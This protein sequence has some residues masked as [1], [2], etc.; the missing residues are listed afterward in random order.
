MAVIIL[1]LLPVFM[2]IAL[3]YGLRRLLLKQE[4][5]WISLERLVYYILF[6]ALLIESLSQANLRAVPVVEVGLSLFAAVILM[7]LLCLALRPWLAGRFGIDGPAF[8]SIFQG[9]LR[10][11][12]F[13]A[14][15]VA[16]NLYGDLG[17]ALASV[18]MVAI[19]PAANVICVTVLARYAAPQRLSWRAIMLTLLRNP[20]IWACA[21]GILLNVTQFPLPKVL[22]SFLDILGRASLGTGLLVVGAGLHLKGLL[23]PKTEVWL[24]ISFKLVLMPVMAIG[25]GMLM[26]LSGANLAVIA[27]CSSVP[28]ASNAYVL[29]RQ[30]GGDGP[31]L[32][33]ILALQT[34]FAVITMPIAIGF[35]A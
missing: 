29:A 8:T 27:C 10:W 11:Q 35:A 15:A 16:A 32:A 12:T 30:M 34:V 2:L 24:P 19:I 20:F 1:A 5:E 23:R 9:S 22:L 28:T 14:L 4:F 13:V 26:K 25:L 18:A 7:A 17:V 33:E 6:P 3:G 21:V 31:L